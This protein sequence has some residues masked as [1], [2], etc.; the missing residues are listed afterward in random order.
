[1]LLFCLFSLALFAREEMTA[2]KSCAAYNNMKHTKNSHHVMLEPSQTY[3]VLEEHKGQMLLLIKGEQPSQRW[4]DEACFSGKEEKQNSV[5]EAIA[6]ID[7]MPTDRANTKKYNTNTSKKEMLLALSWHNAF[8]ETH[9]RKKECKRDMF[10]LF[11]SDHRDH[12][13]ILHGFW[14]QPRN[15]VYCKLDQKYITMDKYKHW[16]KLPNLGLTAE[17]KE[18][19]TKIMPGVHSNLHKHEWVKHGTCYGTDAESYFKKSISLMD[20]FYDSEVSRFFE[21]NIGKRVTL[22]QVRSL[23]DKSFGEGTGKR[24]ELRCRNGLITELWLHL[25]SDSDDLAT[26]LQNGKQ[27]RSSC[28]RGLIDRVGFTK[29]TSTRADL[30]R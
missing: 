3:T 11:K 12:H 30:G 15:N 21:K 14:P 22:R 24:V 23:F 20:Q 10:S 9:R 29:E 17:T 4:V 26:L 27:T 1:M 5:D 2:T 7:K 16:N 28:D 6:K 19:L 18:K 25:G 8:C 13:F